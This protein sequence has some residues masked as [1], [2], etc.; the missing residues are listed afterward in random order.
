VLSWLK[1]PPEQRPH[2]LTLYM[3]DVDS[4]GHD[5]GPGTPQVGTAIHEVDRVIGRLM[6]GIESLP[7]REKVYVVVVSDHGMTEFTPQQ[8]VAIDKLIDTKGIRVADSGPNA[9]LHV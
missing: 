2:M 6:D 4:A 1:L 8:Y 9:N 5:F 3:S 7:Y